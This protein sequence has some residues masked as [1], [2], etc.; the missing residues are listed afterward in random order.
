[1]CVC[2]CLNIMYVAFLSILKSL[3]YKKHFID[4][5]QNKELIK[6]SRGQGW[7]FNNSLKQRLKFKLKSE[8]KQALSSQ[9]LIFIV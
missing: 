8:L 1:M 4:P 3:S 9:H 6:R 5:C 7:V 2:V